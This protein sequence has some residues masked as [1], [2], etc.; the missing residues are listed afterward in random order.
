MA[1][2]A[3][4]G[5]S[6]LAILIAQSFGLA[7]TLILAVSPAKIVFGGGVMKQQALFGPLRDRTAALLAG[8]GRAGDRASLESRIVA[9]ACRE[10]PG[11]IGAYMLGATAIN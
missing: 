8:Y 6:G 5:L 1:G 9:P 4:I 3:V 7:A 11:L 10:A 2:T